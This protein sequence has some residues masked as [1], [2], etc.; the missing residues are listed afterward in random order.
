MAILTSAQRQILNILN[1]AV[2]SKYTI[3]VE[4]S[5]NSE[6]ANLHFHKHWEL[7]FIPRQNNSRCGELKIV[8]PGGKHQSMSVEDMKHRLVLGIGKSLLDCSCFSESAIC[9]YEYIEE[10]DLV[11]SHLEQ[12]ERWNLVNAPIELIKLHG[13]MLL[14]E[15]ELLL[16]R[17]FNAEIN[18]Q[19]RSTLDV[20]TRYIK[21]NSSRCD[22]TVAEIARHAGCCGEQLC[23]LFKNKYNCKAREYIINIRLLAALQLLEENRLTCARVS[24]MTGWRNSDYFARVFKQKLGVTA[25]EFAAKCR[26]LYPKQERYLDV[27]SE[28]SPDLSDFLYMIN[29]IKRD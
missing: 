7:S 18:Q 17:A 20:A 5:D 19:S 22:L 29:N 12:M 26:M 27:L 4:F 13:K 23:R 25:G 11:C 15:I 2:N 9:S 28:L 8:P 14:A 3:Q 6:L 10:A 21:I 16:K 24:Q 1:E